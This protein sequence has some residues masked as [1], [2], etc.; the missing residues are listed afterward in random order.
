MTMVTDP[1]RQRKADPGYPEV[2]TVF[3]YY[4]AL[5]PQMLDQVAEECRT[6]CIGCVQDKKRLAEILIETL[7]P[8]QERRRQF[9]TQEGLLEK[10]VAQGNQ[11]ARTAAR[12]TLSLVREA[13]SLPDFDK[14][15]VL[16]A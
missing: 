15:G 2:C 13:M 4:S 10:V 12:E 1:G 6:A 16:L 11:K 7:A 14:S 9:A 3:A 8:L 5:A